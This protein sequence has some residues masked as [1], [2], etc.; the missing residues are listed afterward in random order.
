MTRVLSGTAAKLQRDL[1]EVKFLMEE[2]EAE[3]SIDFGPE[4]DEHTRRS[5]TDRVLDWIFR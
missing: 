3:T 2:S 4:E 5:W 1:R